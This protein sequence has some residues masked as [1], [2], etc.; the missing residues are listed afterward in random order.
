MAQAPLGISLP[1]GAIGS[2]PAQQLQSSSPSLF[3]ASPSCALAQGSPSHTPGAR[4]V[5][6]SPAGAADVSFSPATGHS[7]P[8]CHQMSLVSRTSPE[9]MDFC[10]FAGGG[11]SGCFRQPRAEV[12]SAS[13]VSSANPTPRRRHCH[14]PSPLVLPFTSQQAV[15]RPLGPVARRSPSAS[16][17]VRFAD[18]SPPVGLQVEQAVVTVIA[19]GGGTGINGSV[20]IELNCDPRFSVNIVGQSRASYDCYPED[21]S[22]GCPPPNLQTFAHDVLAGGTIEKTDLLVVGSRGGQVV[23]PNFWASNAKVPPTVVINGGCAMKL[24]TPVRW[25]SDVITFIL[26]GGQ[27]NFRGHF[28]H[29][30]YIADAKS[31]VPKGNSTT[32][33]L[34]VNEMQH[35]PQAPLL[36]AILPLMLRALQR[37]EELGTA[38]LKEFRPILAALN[39]DGWSGRLLHTRAAGI[40][41]DITFSPC[42]VARLNLTPSSSTLQSSE[43]E[44][45]VPIELTR[46]DELKTLWKAAAARAQP[47]HGA[48]K[49]L[50]GSYFTAVVQAAHQAENIEKS[51]DST[52]RRTRPLLP[53]GVAGRGEAKALRG[54][55]T[56]HKLN[57]AEATPIS[58]ALGLNRPNPFC[59]PRSSYT[60][61]KSTHS[62][63]YHEF[64]YIAEGATGGA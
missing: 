33:I 40:W 44:S 47:N 34:Y 49:S 1:L 29:G 43:D 26:L 3:A 37:W 8:S 35:M 2:M 22:H 53:I 5:V 16:P 25:P 15:D 38:P 41:E 6:R 52:G 46:A 30:E 64:F 48:P 21:W 50:K 58:R 19:P 45:E 31:H 51:E 63:G 7:S 14:D 10:N 28:S 20:Y 55:Y 9:K 4:I 57:T 36:A 27:D 39:R 54:G 18:P 17:T 42:E 23:L 56:P 24:P 13:E 32:A 12:Q 62:T 60:S 11:R 61:P 59:S